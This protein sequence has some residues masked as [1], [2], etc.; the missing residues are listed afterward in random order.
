MFMKSRKW[1]RCFITFCIHLNAY[2]RFRNLII[3]CWFSVDFVQNL[4]WRVLPSM[5]RMDAGS[6]SETD[7]SWALLWWFIVDILFQEARDGHQK[8][9]RG[10]KLSIQW[11]VATGTSFTVEISLY[12]RAAILSKCWNLHE[13]FMK[14]IEWH[15]G[16]GLIAFNVHFYGYKHLQNEFQ[17]SRFLRISFLD[18]LILCFL[19]RCSQ[20]SK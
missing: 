4:H 6:C 20:Y 12:L 3:W 16:I 5:L 17:K 9:S 11:L 1:D 18:F 10:V 14:S 15:H 8:V 2:K 19:D 13:I 7:D